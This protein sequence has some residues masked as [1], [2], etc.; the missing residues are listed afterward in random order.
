MSEMANIMEI[1]GAKM[2]SEVTSFTTIWRKI[3]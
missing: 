3:N 2:P 1:F